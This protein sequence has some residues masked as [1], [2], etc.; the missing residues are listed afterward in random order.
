MNKT[1]LL[2]AI[3]S[4]DFD[5]EALVAQLEEEAA[6][7]RAKKEANAPF[8]ER[9]SVRPHVEAFNTARKELFQPAIYRKD[10]EALGVALTAMKEALTAI[11]EEVGVEVPE[12]TEA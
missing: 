12:T 8:R 3:T 10:P 2:A 9:P 1:E 6:E 4:D 7:E 11:G 5:R